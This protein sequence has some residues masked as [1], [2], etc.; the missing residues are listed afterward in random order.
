MA[1]QTQDL[2]LVAGIIRS[3]TPPTSLEVIWYNTIDRQKYTYETSTSSWELLGSGGAGGGK[4]K[5][6]LIVSLSGGKFMG[7][8]KNGDVILGGTTYEDF[9][10]RALVENIDPTY[11]PASLSLS[12]SAP[13]QGEAGESLTNTITAAFAR[14]DAGALSKLVIELNGA[15]MGVSGNSSPLIRSSAVV[16]GL[17]PTTY[18]A[19]ADYAAGAAKPVPPTNAPDS[20]PLAVRSGNAPQAAEVRMPSNTLTFIGYR[21]LFFGPGTPPANRA[22]ALAL[23]GFQ[24]TSQGNAGTVTTTNALDYVILLPPGKTLTSV[25]DRELSNATITSAYVAQPTVTIKDPSGVDI[26]GYTP[27]LLHVTAPYGSPHHHDFT[28][29]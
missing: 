19:Y 2:G 17:A 21:A 27:Y 8:L 11:T 10:N 24:I 15:L 29:A 16:R 26:P 9:F 13:S 20:R 25:K 22:A 23:G 14:N 5:N 12:Q 7:T 28:Y 18:T 3:A 1:Q 4:F 6:D